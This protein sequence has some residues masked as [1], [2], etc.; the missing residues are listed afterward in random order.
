MDDLL[1]T[2]EL[3]ELLKV[4]RTTVYRMLKSGRLTGIKVG[5]Q[6]RFSRKDVEAILTGAPPAEP[7]E[8]TPGPVYSG[9]LPLHCIQRIQ[10]VFA[11]IAGVGA[12]TAAPSG[13]PLTE[14]SSGC[15]F[16]RLIQASESGR[17][18]CVASWRRLAEQPDH[19]PQFVTCHAGLQ[20]ARSR[21][22]INDNLAAVLVA[23]QFY[24]DTPSPG[25]Q[26]SRVSRLAEAFTLDAAALAEAA[27]EI[28]VLDAHKRTGIGTWLQSVAH[29]FAEIGHER[30]E[31]MGRLRRIAE[32]TAFEPA[33]N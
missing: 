7:V 13:E 26:Q 23:G 3:Q 19:Q 10:N 25:E 30:A 28:P 21:I 20:Y 22:E 8:E 14:M 9:D 1:T 16:C 18:A 11:E 5:E 32:M 29:T 12:V 6:W 33:Q 15:R 4:D 24:A 31:L 27:R 2:R 17:Q